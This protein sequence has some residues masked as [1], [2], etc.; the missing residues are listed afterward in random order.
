MLFS[1]IGVALGNTLFPII[2][3]QYFLKYRATAS[4]LSLS[5]ACVGSFILP[6]AVEYMLRN[7][8]LKG[9]LLITGGFILHVLPA[10]LLMTEPSWIKRNT[11]IK[12]KSVSGIESRKL[13]SLPPVQNLEKIREG[14]VE[15]S[16]PSIH[17]IPSS[18]AIGGDGDRDKTDEDNVQIVTRSA[19]VFSRNG[20]DNPAFLGSKTDVSERNVEEII[21]VNVCYFYIKRFFSFN[22]HTPIL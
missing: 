10:A 18:G 19:R 8:G 9:T 21:E 11:K 5:G 12:Q 14:V 15:T 13:K 4:G 20:V 6:F 7:F 22:R 1:G 16:A 17:K 3:N 2:I